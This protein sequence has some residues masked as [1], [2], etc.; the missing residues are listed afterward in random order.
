MEYS[1]S[2]P[3]VLP[4]S[5]SWAELPVVFGCL[6]LAESTSGR[7]MPSETDVWGV[8]GHKDPLMQIKEET[9]RATEMN[10]PLKWLQ[11]EREDQHQSGVFVCVCVLIW[12]VVC[13]CWS[14]NYKRVSIIAAES[15]SGWFEINTPRTQSLDAD[16]LRAPSLCPS[17]LLLPCSDMFLSPSPKFPSF[18]ERSEVRDSDLPRGWVKDSPPPS[19]PWEMCCPPISLFC[20]HLSLLSS[21]GSPDSVQKESWIWF[22]PL[23]WIARM[24]PGASCMESLWMK[25]G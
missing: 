4:S 18:R 14:Q 25:L 3:R 8:G 5:D 22:P 1:S 10:K 19:P 20:I 24:D 17:A 2:L 21:L 23:F 11:R 13:T 12:L 16:M 7:H 15:D 6:A 9:W